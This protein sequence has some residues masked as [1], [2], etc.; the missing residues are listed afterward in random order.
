MHILVIFTGGTI[1]STIQ[2]GYISTDHKKKY[3]LIEQFKEQTDQDVTFDVLEPY[4]VL[5]ENMT[6]EY[7]SKLGACLES[8]DLSV[9]DGVIMTHGTDTLQYTAAALSYAFPDIEKPVL[10]VSSQYVLDHLDA[11]GGANFAAAVTFVQEKAGTG[12][13]VAYRNADGVVYF[14]KGNRV[15][16][17]LPYSDEVYSVK[18]QY[19]AS[20]QNAHVVKNEGYIDFEE[21]TEKLALHMPQNWNSGILR[22]APFPGMEYPQ[23]DWINIRAVLLDTYHSGTLCSNTPNMTTFFEEAA[24]HKI[25]VFVTGGD[26]NGVDYE[27]VK[28]W[29]ELQVVTLPAA[30]PIA[31]YMKLWMVIDAVNEMS[32][33][34]YLLVRRW[35]ETSVNGDFVTGVHLST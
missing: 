24:K 3:K 19:Y 9:Y 1:G 35:M 7:L 33:D 31:M 13:Y 12:I 28:W 15:L 16:P 18:G 4:T 23:P 25:P 34:S 21:E 6:G 14:H 26:V 2:D 29:K 20:I 11:N 5:S 30:S 17:H 27:S 10:L 8:V 32:E 22:I